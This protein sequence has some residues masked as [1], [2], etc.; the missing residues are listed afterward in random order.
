MA[1]F[2][3]EF[4]H[5]EDRPEQDEL[6]APMEEARGT[7]KRAVVDDLANIR[8]DFAAAKKRLLRV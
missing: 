4:K 5:A 6:A 3:E 1:K 8:L 2:K 7:A